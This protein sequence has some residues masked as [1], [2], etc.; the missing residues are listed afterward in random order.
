MAIFQ[1]I[2]DKASCEQKSRKS[3]PQMPRPLRKTLTVIENQLIKLEKDH[4]GI[5][6][7]I[8]V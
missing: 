6:S 5:Y 3:F 2:I 1:L 4:D 7:L 8:K